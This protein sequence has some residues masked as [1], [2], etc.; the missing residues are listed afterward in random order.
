MSLHTPSRK[1]APPA[2]VRLGGITGCRGSISSFL[3]APHICPSHVVGINGKNA[4][5]LSVRIATVKKFVNLTSY[6]GAGKEKMMAFLFGQFI[7]KY[8]AAIIPARRRSLFHKIGLV[9]GVV[10]VIYFV[11]L[12]FMAIGMYIFFKI[13]GFNG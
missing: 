11:C 2:R 7:M 3:P 8:Y 12:F 1:G 5:F 4:V 6:V 9:A 10:I 13:I